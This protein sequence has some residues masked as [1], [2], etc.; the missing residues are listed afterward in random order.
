LDVGCG[1]KPYECWL[2]STDEYIGVDIHNGPKVDFVIDYAKLWPLEDHT[3]DVVLCTQVMEH[4]V[5][6]ELILGKITQVLKRGGTLIVSTP[7]IYNEHGS[8]DD[9][10]RFSIHGLKQLLSWQYEVVETKIEGR[11]GSVIGLLCLNW[12]EA[13][14]NQSKRIRLL[15]GLF[16]PLWI[17]FC[18]V[19]NS[20]GW[21][22]DKTDRTSSFYINVLLIA[23][24]RL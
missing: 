23:R 20:L 5:D 21:L 4:A 16:L 2:R 22:I 6:I 10:R 12:V 24:K 18:C 19:V 14:T 17:L 8:P 11:I 7:F 9:Y 15:K 1:D 13:I 3:F